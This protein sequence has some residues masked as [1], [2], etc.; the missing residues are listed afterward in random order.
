[1]GEDRTEGAW[2]DAST[3]CGQEGNRW[4]PSM[5]CDPSARSVCA[6]VASP[7][8]GEPAATGRRARILAKRQVRDLFS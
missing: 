4:P 2:E 5:V 8:T 7:P 6:D 1:M 3:A